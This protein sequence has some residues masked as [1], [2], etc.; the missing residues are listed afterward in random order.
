MFRREREGDLSAGTCV[1]DDRKKRFT[2][3]ELDG[4]QHHN[5]LSVADNLKLT[6]ARYLEIICALAAIHTSLASSIMQ[7]SHVTIICEN[8]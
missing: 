7:H 6:P 4:P 5:S 1:A 3:V 2:C 8:Y